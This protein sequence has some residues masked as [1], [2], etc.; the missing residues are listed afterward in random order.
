MA[1]RYSRQLEFN[2][3]IYLPDCPIALEKGAVLLDTKTNAYVLQLKF[4]NIGTTGIASARICVEAL[5]R[6]GQSVYSEI[7][8]T[9]DE[10]TDMGST[11]GTKKLLPVPN[12]NAVTFHVYAEKV[13]T[14]DGHSYSF[15]RKQYMSES[16]QSDITAMREEVAYEVAQQ[17]QVRQSAQSTRGWFFSLEIMAAMA[18][19]WGLPVWE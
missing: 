10:H 12:N 1:D 19:A 3:E 15:S 17:K 9:Y 5:D 14:V 4:A 13:T 6:T 8:T 18:S 2:N 11:F 16:H 7:K